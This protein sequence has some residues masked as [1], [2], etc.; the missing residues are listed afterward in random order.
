[1]ARHGQEGWAERRPLR[2]RSPLARRSP[3]NQAS[4]EDRC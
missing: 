3:I 1:V 2:V 4:S